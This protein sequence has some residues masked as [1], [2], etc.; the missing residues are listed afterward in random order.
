SQKCDTELPVE[1]RRLR[2]DAGREPQRMHQEQPKTGYRD[3]KQ[4]KAQHDCHGR[5]WRPFFTSFRN[6]SCTRVS[7]ESS[8]WKVQAMILP[9][10]TSAGSAPSLAST[11]TSLPAATIFGARMNTISKG[12]PPSLVTDS[13]MVLST[14][15]P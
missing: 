13:R 8:G 9:W 7:R 1:L 5:G 10:R 11:S 6:S 4:R 2:G 15:L 14:C 12:G 3:Y